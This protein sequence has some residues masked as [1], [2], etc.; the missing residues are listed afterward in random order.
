MKRIL[1]IVVVALI[2][3]IIL[4]VSA[5]AGPLKKRNDVHLSYEQISTDASFK[6]FKKA[7]KSN[8]IEILHFLVSRANEEYLK[9]QTIEDL[10]NVKEQL[11]I[12]KFYN[13][14]AKQKSIAVTNAIR[15]L[16]NQITQSEAEYKKEVIIEG[17][18]TH[19]RDRGQEL[20]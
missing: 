13:E 4:P 1:T 3:A 19:Y 5:T 7:T 2:A 9:C 20:K 12:I 10:Y 8:Q 18:R 6:Q 14:T 17:T 16:D 11:D 15:K